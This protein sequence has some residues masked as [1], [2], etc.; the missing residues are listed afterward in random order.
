VSAIA[1]EFAL[2]GQQLTLQSARRLLATDAVLG[3]AAVA[4]LVIGRCA[5]SISRR[6]RPIIFPATHS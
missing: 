3:F 1:V 4:L 6:A 5:S 2:I